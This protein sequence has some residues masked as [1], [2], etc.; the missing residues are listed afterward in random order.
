ME[1]KPNKNNILIKLPEKIK[2]AKNILVTVSDNPTI[3]EVASALGLN[4]V[5]DKM[6][7]RCTAIYS[8]SLLSKFELLNT[9]DVFENNTDS[10]QDFIITI[11]KSKADSLRYKPEGEFVKIYIAPYKTRL[12]QDDL[13]FS[14]GDYNVDLVI[15]LNVSEESK[16]D[17]ALVAHKRMFH[18]VDVINL[19]I[20]E[21]GKIAE[22]EW[23]DTGAGAISEMAFNLVKKVLAEETEGGAREADRDKK[24]IDERIATAFLTGITAST[25]RFSNE[26]TSVAIM[27]MAGELMGLGAKQNLVSINIDNVNDFSSTKEAQIEFDNFNE[28]PIK[29]GGVEE[30]KK[31]SLHENEQGSDELRDS[32]QADESVEKDQDGLVIERS[33]KFAE[34]VKEGLEEEL[35]AEREKRIE[36][37]NL[38][39][40]FEARQA[41]THARINDEIAKE[42]AEI[43]R[44]ESAS[45]SASIPPMGMMPP[46]IEN[47][48]PG[49]APAVGVN[50]GQN[51]VIVPPDIM[52]LTN[53]NLGSQPILNPSNMQYTDLVPPVGSPLM[54]D[55]GKNGELE[56]INGGISNNSSAPV[57]GSSMG[58]MGMPMGGMNSPMGGAGAPMTDPGAFNIPGM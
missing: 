1:N 6:G 8:G 40:S 7:K 19:S 24:I 55:M 47:Y 32:A 31:I 33:S 27:N 13:S 18:N 28:T 23:N 17:T 30:Q 14:R 11:D 56:I 37:E 48:V 12:T 5:F 29:I 42:L 3:D 39:K 44:E 43:N 15:L 57:V 53:N 4:L 21:A 51:S 52:P 46:N 36:L 26:K 16:V 20:A 25:E 35:P 41:E 22:L 2:A 34:S 49:G 9:R 38:Q 58:E 45:S 50:G 54:P 10:L